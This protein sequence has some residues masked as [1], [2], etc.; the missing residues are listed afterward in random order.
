MVDRDGFVTECGAMSF[1]MI[2]NGALYARPLLGELLPGITRQTMLR[3]A[4]KEGLTI[5]EERYKL[6]DTYTAEEAFATGASS[7]IQP[8]VEIDGHRIGDGRAGP[9]T[10]SLRQAYLE[11]VRGA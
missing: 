10:L 1:F 9:I 8:V 4:K 2:K 6:E 3:V 7:Y 11:A 5:A